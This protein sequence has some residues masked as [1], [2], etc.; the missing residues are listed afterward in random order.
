[1]V[2]SGFNQI[3]GQTRAVFRYALQMGVFAYGVDVDKIHFKIT[4][5]LKLKCS[6]R[7]PLRRGAALVMTTGL[8][9]RFLDKF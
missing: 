9:S 6:V 4:S 2:I 8:I 7:D 1:M 3:A 5:L